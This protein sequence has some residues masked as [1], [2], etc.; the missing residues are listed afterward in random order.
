[1]TEDIVYDDSAWPTTMC[2]HADV[3]AFL[4]HTW[5]GL[6]DLRFTVRGGP[7]VDADAT[8][9]RVLVGR[10][11]NAH[12]RRSIRPGWRPRAARWCSTAPTSTST[13]D[14]KVCRLRI[15]FDMADIMRQLGVL[16]PTGGGQERAMPS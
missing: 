11:R 12:R 9:G 13:G 15:V 3:R 8:H 10:P 4:E 14:G 2:G 6:P 7:Y 1:M 5:R 16:P